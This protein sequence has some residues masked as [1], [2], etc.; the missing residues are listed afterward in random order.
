MAYTKWRNCEKCEKMSTS[1]KCVCC[2]EIAVVKACHLKFKATLSWNTAVLEFFAVEFNCVGNHF[3]EEP[4]SEISKKLFLS[5]SFNISKITSFQVF[6]AVILSFRSYFDHVF[7]KVYKISKAA[8]LENTSRPSF[9]LYNL[10]QSFTKTKI[11][12]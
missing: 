4:F 2:H 11:L 9:T 1:L 5:I 10:I 6:L 3:L 12:L 8:F 7:E